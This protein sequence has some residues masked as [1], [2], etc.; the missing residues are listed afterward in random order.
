MNYNTWDIILIEFPFSDLSNKKLRPA[1]VISNQS[2]NNHN[3]LLL[4][5]I[6]WN[7]WISEYS[8]E[9]TNNDLENW[10]LNKISY[11][12]FHNIFSLEKNLIKSKIAELKKDK[13]TQVKDKLISFIN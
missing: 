5:W 3:N 9:L 12:R 7:K 8:L 2:F 4:I 6:Y 13:L 10:E 1:L 11:F